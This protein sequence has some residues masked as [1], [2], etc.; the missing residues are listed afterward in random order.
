VCIGS[1]DSNVE[2]LG[3]IFNFFGTPVDAAS[4]SQASGGV[5]VLWPG[6]SMLSNYVVF[7]ERVALAD[8][9]YLFR[10]CGLDK[11]LPIMPFSNSLFLCVFSCCHSSQPPEL[12]DLFNRMMCYNPLNRITAADSLR[13]AYFD[14]KVEPAATPPDQLPRPASGQ[15]PASSG[16]HRSSTSPPSKRSRTMPL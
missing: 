16:G 6:V 3:L 14:P 15:D 11:C 9:T 12:L 5:D 10:W 2:Q 13:H 7:E 8:Y 1:S 4:A